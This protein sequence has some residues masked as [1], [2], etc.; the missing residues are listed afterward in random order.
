[1]P[2]QEPPERDPEHP[3][4]SDPARPLTIDDVP[5]LGS[6]T[7]IALGCAGLVIVAT[8]LFWLVRGWVMQP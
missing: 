4:S 6:G 8:L 2:S 7:G 1:M 5:R 3:V